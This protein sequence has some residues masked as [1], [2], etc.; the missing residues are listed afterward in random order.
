MDFQHVKNPVF[1]PGQCRACVTHKD[2]DGFVDLI[3]EDSAGFRFYLCASCLFQAGRT[4]GMLSP[5]Q[6]TG[7]RQLVVDAQEAVTILERELAV[8]RENKLVSL[9][10]VRELIRQRGGRPPSATP[11]AA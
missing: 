3:A 8:E 2:K 9:A 1:P 11:T 10:D 7:L 5:D 6:A 4:L